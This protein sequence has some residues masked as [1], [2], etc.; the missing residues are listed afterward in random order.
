MVL[1]VATILFI[2]CFFIIVYAVGI[3][4]WVDKKPKLV[5]GLYVGTIILVGWA[6]HYFTQI[7]GIP[8]GD[9]VWHQIYMIMILTAGPL[10][11][12]MSGI[13]GY[14]RYMKKYMADHYINE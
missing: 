4:F 5:I 14:K 10:S 9:Q 8:E 6:W 7:P 3:K 13:V 12:L 2:I 11:I 1:I